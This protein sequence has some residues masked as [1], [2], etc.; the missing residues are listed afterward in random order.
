VALPLESKNAAQLG[1]TLAKA[2]AASGQTQEQIAE[3]LGVDPETISRFERGATWP[4]LPR[5]LSLAELYGVPVGA[6]F[7]QGSARAVDV[8]EEL[9]D[10]LSQLND[11]DRVWVRQWLT[12]LC[13][14][15]ASSSKTQHPVKKRP[16]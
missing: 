11:K 15:L 7:R 16:R 8:A 3:L 1:R 14:R 9:V 13:D 5:L 10:K 2:R 4:T 6:F 12:E